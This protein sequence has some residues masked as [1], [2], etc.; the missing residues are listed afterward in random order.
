MQALERVNGSG[1]Y[2]PMASGF[3]LSESELKQYE[4]HLA[5]VAEQLNR[6]RRLP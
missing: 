3:S 5:N 6:V 4:E 2:T 1:V